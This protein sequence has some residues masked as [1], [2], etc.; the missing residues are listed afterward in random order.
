MLAQSSLERSK[1]PTAH[2][3]G[4]AAAAAGSWNCGKRANSLRLPSRTAALN[5]SPKSQKNRK[6]VAAPNSSPMKTSGGDGASSTM[7]AAAART[8]A[9]R[10]AST[11]RQGA[12]TH[13]VVVLEI[14]YERLEGQASGLSPRNRR[15]MP[16]ARPDRRIRV[17]HRPISL[18]GSRLKSA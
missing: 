18:T 11:V 17:R 9:R 4:I 13:L 14:R 5:S 2:G 3:S 7:T 15:E 10:A 16:K 6:G 8:W 12:V 1:V